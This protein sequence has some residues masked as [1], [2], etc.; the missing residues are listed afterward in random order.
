MQSVRE[1]AASKTDHEKLGFIKESLLILGQVMTVAR[2]SA[3]Q[4]MVGAGNAGGVGYRV[5]R[6]VGQEAEL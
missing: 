1:Q 2:Q 5:G 4:I 3:S 6:T